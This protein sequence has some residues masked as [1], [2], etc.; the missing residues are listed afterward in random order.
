M[1]TARLLESHVD[2]GCLGNRGRLGSAPVLEIAFDTAE[3]ALITK[4]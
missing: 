3:R 4:D 2:R 1:H